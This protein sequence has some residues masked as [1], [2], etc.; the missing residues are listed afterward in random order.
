[1]LVSVSA[2]LILKDLDLIQKER[3]K[4]LRVKC[5]I[6]QPWTFTNSAILSGIR[7]SE[8]STDDRLMSHP[9][10]TEPL[11][12]EL[13]PLIT[14][15]DDESSEVNVTDPVVRLFL[16]RQR[17]MKEVKKRREAGVVERFN[18]FAVKKYYTIRRG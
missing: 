17:R 9:A 11:P 7:P 13:Q 6:C 10:E 5:E 4:D 1:M 3:M 2:F 18:R 15:D 8:P 12:P 16:K 14:A